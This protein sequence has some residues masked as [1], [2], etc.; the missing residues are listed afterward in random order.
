M[1][2]PSS[3][4]AAAGAAGA[5]PRGTVDVTAKDLDRLEDEEF[6]NDTIIDFYLK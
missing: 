2:Y 5:A 4:N 1:R 6:L 3:V